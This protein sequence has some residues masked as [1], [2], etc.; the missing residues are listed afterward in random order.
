MDFPG[1]PIRLRRLLVILQQSEVIQQ[2]LEH[3]RITLASGQVQKLFSDLLGAQFTRSVAVF[4]DQVVFIMLC[5]LRHPKF[6]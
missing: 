6:A 3:D 5:R 2:L 1:P 4:P